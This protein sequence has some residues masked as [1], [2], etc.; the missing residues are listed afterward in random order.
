MAIVLAAVD[1]AAAETGFGVA[2]AGGAA[3]ALATEETDCALEVEALDVVDPPEPELP[4]ETLEVEVEVEPVAPAAE[5]DAADEFAEPPP[6]VPSASAWFVEPDVLLNFT[7]NAPD[8]E[9]AP[10]ST[11][12]FAPRSV[13]AIDSGVWTSPR[14]SSEVSRFDE[15]AMP[16]GERALL[17]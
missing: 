3:V 1:E 16:P 6:A 7:V 2:A 14:T 9:V 5:T 8:G 13:S 15:Y 12:V 4:L 17:A 10:C 11:E